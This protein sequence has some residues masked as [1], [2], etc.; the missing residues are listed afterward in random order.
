MAFTELLAS[1]LTDLFSIGLMVALVF[2]AW[3]NRMATGWV[4]PLIAGVVFVAVIIPSTMQSQSV[5][6]L[7]RLVATGIAANVI[8][9]AATLAIYA[10]IL[11]L[12]RC[13]KGSG[14][15]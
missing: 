6:P 11:K 8:I 10:A 5:E 15:V 2:T 4:L 13:D 7:W 14:R 9:L 1:Q 12:R 3:R